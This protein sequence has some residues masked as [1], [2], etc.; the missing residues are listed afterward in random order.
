MSA[1]GCKLKLIHLI[2]KHRIDILMMIRYGNRVRSHDELSNIFCNDFKNRSHIQRIIKHKDVLMQLGW[3]KIYQK[4]EDR[5]LQGTKL[6]HKTLDQFKIQNTFSAKP[7][8][9]RRCVRE[10]L[11]IGKN[12]PYKIQL[13][14]KLSDDDFNSNGH[15]IAT[16]NI[17]QLMSYFSLRQPFV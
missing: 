17:L 4:L 11:K 10:I 8:L 15:L 12:H 13:V 2:E 7:C 16:S 9:N 6:L 3:S 5:L 14:K 1:I